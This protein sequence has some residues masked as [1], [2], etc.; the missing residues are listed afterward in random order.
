MT[1]LFDLAEPLED[2]ARSHNVYFAIQPDAQAVRALCGL[3]G[4]GRQDPERLHISLYSLG[5]HAD[6]PH[7][8]ISEAT[9]A[10]SAVRFAPFVVALDRLGTWGRGQGVLPV[11]AWSD[12]GVIG[13]RHLHEQLCAALAE[14]TGR[15]REPAVE[16]HLTLWRDAIRTPLS[17]FAPIAWAV[18]EFVLVDSLRSKGRCEVL[19]RFPLVG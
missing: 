9:R 18:R 6:L 7:G 5:R 1:L 17:F 10:A 11:V 4:G 14:T 8:R 12:D 16:P 13:V 15:R 2:R 19:A 3:A